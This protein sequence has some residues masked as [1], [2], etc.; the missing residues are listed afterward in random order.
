MEKKI[1]MQDENDETVNELAIKLVWLQ[2]CGN[3]PIA[4]QRGSQERISRM[5]MVPRYERDTRELFEMLDR[6]LK[7]NWIEF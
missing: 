3:T 4:E 1:G 2:I 7:I 6:K 5:G